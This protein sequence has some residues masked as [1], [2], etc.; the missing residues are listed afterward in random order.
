MEHFITTY[1]HPDTKNTIPELANNRVESI[2][3]YN[4]YVGYC[5]S[6]GVRKETILTHHKFSLNLTELQI[7]IE[8]FKDERTKYFSMEFDKIKTIMIQRQYIVDDSKK[9][10]IVEDCEEDCDDYFDYSEE[11]TTSEDEI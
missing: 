11:A 8:L 4:K 9:E 1:D 3:L 10:D 6:F 5:E 7:G 2:T